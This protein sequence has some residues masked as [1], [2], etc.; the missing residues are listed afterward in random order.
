MADVPQIEIKDLPKVPTEAG[1]LRIT[2]KP[3]V[4]PQNP[5]VGSMLVLTPEP[6]V[7]PEKSLYQKLMEKPDVRALWYPHYVGVYRVSKAAAEWPSD[8][9]SG[10][11]AGPLKINDVTVLNASSDANKI[12]YDANQMELGVVTEWTEIAIVHYDSTATP[13][14]LELA[15]LFRGDGTFIGGFYLRYLNDSTS[16]FAVE[17]KAKFNSNA[18]GNTPFY[19][20]NSLDSW[21]VIAVTNTYNPTTGELFSKVRVNGLDG[22]PPRTGEKTSSIGAGRTS[23]RHSTA[24]KFELNSSNL[25]KPALYAR[26]SYAMTA[27]QQISFLDDF[28]AEHNI[29]Q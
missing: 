7:A 19:G 11:P 25:F 20:I 13:G 6:D 1:Q 2:V 26:M 9:N 22:V 17:A 15:R 4:D 14:S 12:E 8:L 18:L 23:F 10:Q 5:M 3:G 24:S 21:N 16:V 27:E 28:K 29:T